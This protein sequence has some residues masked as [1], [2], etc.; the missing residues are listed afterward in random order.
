MLIQLLQNHYLSAMEEH[1]YGDDHGTRI[2]APTNF[3]EF[4]EK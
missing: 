3:M 2:N 1:Y 4:I